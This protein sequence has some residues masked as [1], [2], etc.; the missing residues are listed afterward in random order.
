MIPATPFATAGTNQNQVEQFQVS[1][2][3]DSLKS[4][5]SGRWTIEKGLIE[6]NL[7]YFSNSSRPDSKFNGLPGETYTLRWTVSGVNPSESRVQISFKPMKVEITNAS[8]QNSTK[9]YLIGTMYRGG[10]WTVEGQYAR[11]LNQIHGGT[12]IDVINSPSIEFQSYAN[13]SYKLTWTSYYGS[14]SASASIEFKSGEYL[15]S[16]ALADLQLDPSSYRVKY[17][18]G[19]ITRLNLAA[20][21][22]AWILSDTLQHPALQA[23]KYLKE[24]DLSG[25]ATY[26]FPRLIGE[27]FRSLEYLN[28]ESTPCPEFADN[29]GNLKKLKKLIIGHG[30]YGIQIVSLPESFGNLESLEYFYATA[31][32]LRY[33]PFSFGKLKKL[34]Y[35]EAYLNPLSELPWDIGELSDLEVMMISSASAMPSSITKLSKLRRL[36]YVSS[37][38]SDAIPAN[39]DN[40]TSLDSLTLQSKFS[41]IPN[42]FGNLNISQLELNAT[43]I[44][45]VPESFGNLKN[46]R[47]L[48]LGGKF[49]TLPAGLGNL[50]NVTSVWIQSLDLESLPDRIG[51]LKKLT[52]IN[53]QSTKIKTLPSS[54]GDLPELTEVRFDGNQIESIPPNFFNLKKLRTAYFTS[55]KISAISDD[56]AKLANTLV[57]LNVA[58][59]NFPVSDGIKLKQLLPRTAVTTGYY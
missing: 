18:N 31:S 27:K 55:N 54:I 53:V 7:V 47:S 4:N 38:S 40:L 33:L 50:S 39:F 10:K 49:K 8:P 25:S 44:T 42:S 32:G 16:E 56:F 58:G 13:T 26:I 17:E 52:Y 24:L 35:L 9:L 12:V 36:Y 37:T 30:M 1:L 5:Q 41:S 3:A 43:N 45:S 34:K 46:L 14:K 21:G 22:I 6:D 19:H 23:L 29:I 20:S 2:N 59:N 48:I 57:I 51:D 28:I 11:M 15:E